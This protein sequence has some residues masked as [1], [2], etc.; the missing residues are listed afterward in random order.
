MRLLLLVLATTAGHGFALAQGAISATAPT[1]AEVVNRELAKGKG[2]LARPASGSSFLLPYWTRGRVVMTSGIVPQPW[3]KFDLAG[4]RLLW[5]RSASDSLQLDT[6][7]MTEFSLR[8][9]LHGKT[10]TYRR[11]LTAKIK[12]LELRT[13]FF[14]VH[15]DAGHSAL[16]QR[17]NRILFHTNN[18]PS[19]LAREG[20]KWQEV[21]TYY[22]KRTDDVLEP[23][24]LNAKSVLYVLGKEKSPLLLAYAA[25]ERLNL[26]QE[27][28]VV[29][30]LQY[31][32]TL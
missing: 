32:D 19:L 31:Y 17:R 20:D 7:A 25:R 11:Y 29:K 18:G 28:D 12:D 10:Y 6:S 5:R 4:D 22:L 23:V 9:S 30:L 14:E 1:D 15:Y 24:R 26:S 3:L 16:L 27:P 21:S 8:D 13:A 2:N